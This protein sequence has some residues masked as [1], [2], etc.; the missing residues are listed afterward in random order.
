MRR[1]QRG[2]TTVEFAIIGVVLMVVLFAIL[3]MGRALF[4]MN[5]LTEVTRRG[6]RIAAV[7]PVTNPGY[8]AGVAIFAPGGGGSPVVS[9]LTAANVAIEYLDQDGAVVADPTTQAVYYTRARLVNFTLNLAIPLVLPSIAMPD[10]AATV[11]AESLGY[12]RAGVL[13]PCT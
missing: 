4:V 6:A 8:A 11:P 13:E 7:C 9:G 3:E 2:I 10:F 5:T 1:Y 12:S